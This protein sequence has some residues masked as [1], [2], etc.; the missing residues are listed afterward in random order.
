MRDEFAFYLETGGVVLG[1]ASALDRI[2]YIEANEIKSGRCWFTTRDNDTVI[3][4]F[5]FGKGG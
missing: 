2:H 3:D 5:W 4:E 1:F